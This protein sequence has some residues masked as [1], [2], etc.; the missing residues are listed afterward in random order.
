[1]CGICQGILANPC[2]AGCTQHV[3]CY[4]CLI[5]Y[6]RTKSIEQG[7]HSPTFPCPICRRECSAGSIQRQDFLANIIRSESVKCTNVSL[8]IAEDQSCDWIG[9]LSELKA[10]QAQCPLELI[11]CKWCNLEVNRMQLEC[12]E[13]QCDEAEIKCMDCGEIG[14][15]RKLMVHHTVSECSNRK[16]CRSMKVSFMN[17]FMIWI[18]FEHRV[19]VQIAIYPFINEIYGIID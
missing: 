5:G 11:K 3:F 16:V 18:M 1:M 17:I 12:H 19:R 4:K 8:C 14:I 2:T 6:A 15:L 13:N 7:S 9:P 10:H